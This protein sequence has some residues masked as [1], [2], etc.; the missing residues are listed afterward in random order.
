MCAFSDRTG[1][2]L[3]LTSRDV[4]DVS[5]AYPR[6]TGIVE[7]TDGISKPP[8]QDFIQQGP[9]DL[10]LSLLAQRLG[11]KLENQVPEPN[12]TVRWHDG[13]VKP[14][15]ADALMQNLNDQTS[16]IYSPTIMPADV[17]CMVEGTSQSAC[18]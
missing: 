4:L 9:L 2:N 17:W 7:M 10:F 12:L 5:G 11:Y 1:V 14:E 3:P 16:L 13:V 18:R 6:S 8:R 15:T